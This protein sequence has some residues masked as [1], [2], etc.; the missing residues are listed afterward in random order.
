M[1]N[2]EGMVLLHN[3]YPFVEKMAEYQWTIN[4]TYMV[5]AKQLA[6]KSA[7]NLT[8]LKMFLNE[9]CI[10]SPKKTWRL[11][12]DVVTKTCTHVDFRQVLFQVV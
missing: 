11:L 1:F 5:K 12:D 8:D 9:F 10:A 6:D 2:L 4:K 3:K 7:I